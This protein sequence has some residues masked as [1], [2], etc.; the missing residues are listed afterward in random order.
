MKHIH[1]IDCEQDCES[2]SVRIL[3]CDRCHSRFLGQFV[4][5][6]RRGNEKYPMCNKC[7]T[8]IDGILSANGIEVSK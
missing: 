7:I 3:V 6:K 2:M 5:A 8:D 4:Y 1:L